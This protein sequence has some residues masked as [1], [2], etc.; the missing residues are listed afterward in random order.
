MLKVGILGAG[1][2]AGTMA[3][4]LRQMKDVECC[5]VAARDADR[6]KAF[7]E[8][9]GFAEAYGSY[10]EMLEHSQAELIYVATPH[11][12]HYAHVKMCLEHGKHVLCE[13]AFML[14]EKQAE[15]VFAMAKERGLLLTEAIWTRYMPI[16]KTLDQVLAS[17]I[18]GKPCM[19]TAN[20][21]YVTSHKE[22]I[23]KL[24]LGGGALLD[25]GVYTLNFA[26]M[27]FGNG[28]KEIKGQAVFNEDGADMQNSVTL[29]YEDGR[30][31]VLNSTAMG[32]SDRSGVI[33]G[34]KGYIVAA[35]INN[36]QGFKVYNTSD[37][38]LASYDR[39]EQISGYEYQ[40][41][42][43][44][45]AIE[46]GALECPQMPHEESLTIMRWMDNLRAQWGMKF[47]GE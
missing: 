22:R 9:Y 21:G 27:V 24:E 11:S 37:E 44:Q 45:E 2:I 17:G 20:L 5:A 14:Y 12:H 30:M 10:E 34:D 13:K 7:A 36:C 4:T 42:A 19:L 38:L 16:R 18:I 41:I 6:A 32:R 25:V 29:I 35:N 26:S 3:R 33:Y 31:A 1:N 23:K 8:T 39:P 47:P 43:C 40:V 28:V 46:K 15:E